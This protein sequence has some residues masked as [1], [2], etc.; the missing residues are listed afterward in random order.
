LSE[1]DADP[2]LPSNLGPWRRWKE[3]AIDGISTGRIGVAANDI[4]TF[5]RDGYVIL[6]E[7]LTIDD[8]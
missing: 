6:R 1:R 4:A 8:V 5:Q 2:R 3:I 7:G